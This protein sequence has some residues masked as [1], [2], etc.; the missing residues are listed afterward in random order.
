MAITKND[1]TK[2]ADKAEKLTP[3]TDVAAS[4]AM[5]EP[6]IVSRIDTKNASVDDNPRKD[7]TPDMNQI[8]FNVPSGVQSPEETVEE[9]L[10]G[11]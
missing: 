4:G 10:K 7:S 3:A 5:I 9:N 2:A 1:T 6:E 8:D 11:E